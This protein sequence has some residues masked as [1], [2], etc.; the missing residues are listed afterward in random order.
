MQTRSD[1][2]MLHIRDMGKVAVA[3]T[4]NSLK[5]G[6]T[7]ETYELTVTELT[8]VPFSPAPQTIVALM[9]HIFE[10]VT[11]PAGNDGFGRIRIES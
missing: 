10:V 11:Q 7:L 3:G 4:R 2:T 1:E 5:Y 6:A 9:E 8:Y